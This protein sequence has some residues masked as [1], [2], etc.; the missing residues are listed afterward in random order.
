VRGFTEALHSILER[1]PALRP[2]V[3]AIVV[4]FALSTYL[5]AAATATAGNVGGW[6]MDD[7]KAFYCAGSALRSRESPYDSSA[8]GA[9][10]ARPVPRPLFT[11]RSGFAL[12]AP[13]PGYAIVPFALL[14]AL[15]FPDAALLWLIVLAAS[16]A[17]A[18]WLLARLG[19][20]D[21][22][23]S[24]VVFA[25]PLIAISFTVGEVVP[26]AFLG[27]ALAA[28][29]ARGEA[30]VKSSVV[31]GLGIALSFAEPQ[32]GIAIAIACALLEPRYTAVVAVVVAAL[33]AISIGAV[34]IEANIAYV[35]DVLPA[36][37]FS[38]LPAYFQYSLSWVLNQWGMPAGTALLLGRLQWIAMLATCAWFARTAL[39]QEH[40]ELAV[41]GAAAFAVTG[42]PF[43]HLDH[44]ALAVPAALWL[45]T[46]RTQRS[47]L[48]IAALVALAIPFLH[49]VVLVR[50]VSP[51]W[52][53]L[54][55]VAVA[56]WLGS[57]YGRPAV[58]ASMAIGVLLVFAIIDVSGLLMRTVSAGTVA[59]TALAPQ[60]PWAHFVASHYAFRALPFWLAKLPTWFALIATTASLVAAGWGY[61]R[62][63]ERY[64]AVTY[65]T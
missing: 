22:W 37:I 32:V 18:F 10:E 8:I 7:F 14:A 57:E 23:R 6:V 5:R 63:K 3:A 56:G 12:P 48:S 62:R 50:W 54:F 38:E 20:G 65:A 33:G 39:A 53:V 9:C 41:F 40:R 55:A 29:G 19:L 47:V 51:V 25:V 26:V 49:L 4:A 13:L 46:R 24:A 17:A 15:P 36:H 45:V 43:L 30:S 42:G 44:T 34:G 59:S 11:A 35:R 28:W 64:G 2:I 52:L 61:G 21:A 27:V 58:G 60:G 16:A 1:A 31:L